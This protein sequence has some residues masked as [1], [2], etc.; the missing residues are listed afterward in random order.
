V[1]TKDALEVIF[2]RN[3]FYRRLHH[4]ALGALA[5]A[6]LMIICLTM[7]FLYL[8]RNPSGP[9]YFAADNVSRLINIIPVSSPNMTTQEV[10]QWSIDAI[11]SAYSYDY[12]NYREQLQSTQKYFTAYGWQEYMRALTASNNLIA[13]IQRRQVAVARVVGTPKIITEGILAGAYAWKFEMPVLITY[14]LPPYDE[15]SKFLNARK[16]SV[17]VQRQQVLQAYK[18]LGIIQLVESL[19]NLSGPNQPQ[20]ITALPS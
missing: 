2:L 7:A 15:K 17:I 5:L 18:G 16:V 13:V 3:F 4:Y 1:E 6:I 8:Y 10:M 19:V 14:Y 9:I 20:E 12:I 11:Q